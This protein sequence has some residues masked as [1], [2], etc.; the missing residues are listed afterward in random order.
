MRLNKTIKTLIQKT[1]R[2]GDKY[3]IG[4][5][6]GPDSLCL[7]H[8]LAQLQDQLD[9]VLYA[10]HLDHQLRGKESKADAEFVRQTAA[11]WNIPLVMA[12]A[13]IAS[14][15]A[16]QKRGTEE[17]ARQ[18]RYAF[19]SQ[20]ARQVG[21]TKVLVGHNADDQAET[22]LMHLLRGSGLA[23]L[24]GMAPIA[25]YPFAYLFAGQDLTLLRPLLT[26]YRSAIMAYCQEHGL[27]PR[28]DSSNLNTAFFRNRLRHDLLPLLE[29]VSPG[30]NG[31]LCQLAELVAADYFLLENLV[32]ESWGNVL[33]TDSDQAITL[34]ITAWRALPLGLRRSTLRRAVSRLRGSQRDLTFTQVENARRIAETGE[35]GAQATLTGRLRLTVGYEQLQVADE[36]IAPMPPLE[37]PMLDGDSTIS[38][39]VPGRTLLP[40]SDWQVDARW[41]SADAETRVKASRNQDAW[42][43]FLD[44]DTVGTSLVLRPRRPGERFQPLGMGGKSSSVSDF[45]INCQIP[46]A[47]R[48]RVPILA[49][50][51]RTRPE[52]L[53]WIAGWRLDERAKITEQTKR[54]LL[55]SFLSSLDR[56]E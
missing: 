44:A 37:W 8:V 21:A 27:Q 19:L 16:A 47:W 24:R 18:E 30:I 14:L 40:G 1:N 45:M 17:V 12:T 42:R 32:D 43:A 54:I 7:L 6:G 52:Q 15:A 41:L 49:L 50:R 9:L 2:P 20:V 5:S 46:R 29:Q 53:L 56:A 39:T 26:V 11:D 35:C 51:T 3:V 22:V 28:A 31:R 48:D 33:G 10:A 4:I 13:D 23:G 25:P 34:D 38:L 55:I 36:G